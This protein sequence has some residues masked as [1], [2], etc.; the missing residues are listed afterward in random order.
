[1]LPSGES[2]GRDPVNVRLLRLI[3]DVVPLG[4]DEIESRS[5]L[6]S[7]AAGSTSADGRR[8]GRAATVGDAGRDDVGAGDQIAPAERAA[9]AEGALQARRPRQRS[10]VTIAILVVSGGTRE[11][12]ECADRHRRARRRQHD[13]GHRGGVAGRGRAFGRLDER[14]GGAEETQPEKQIS[15][16]LAPTPTPNCAKASHTVQLA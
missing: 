1:M 15:S 4:G 3:D 16:P 8:P 12:H 10:R 9:R 13:A 6:C 7:P 5:G 14:L 2:R 11:V